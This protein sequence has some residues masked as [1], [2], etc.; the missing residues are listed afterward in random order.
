MPED[1]RTLSDY[2][3]R[4]GWTAHLVLHVCGGNANLVKTLTGK[5]ITVEA[6]SSGV[7]DCAK[8]KILDKDV[9]G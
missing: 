6:N 1:G 7:A 5:V 2:K 4:E 9:E 3:I 8:A